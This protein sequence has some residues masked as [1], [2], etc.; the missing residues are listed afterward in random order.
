MKLDREH[1]CVYR[2]TMSVVKAVLLS[3]QDIMDSKPDDIFLL[4]KVNNNKKIIDFFFFFFL[5]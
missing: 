2:D 3:N 4:V 5:D 1:D